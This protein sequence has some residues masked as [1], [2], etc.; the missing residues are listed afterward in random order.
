MWNQLIDPGAL[1]AYFQF[2][3]AQGGWI[4]TRN[5]ARA[6]QMK[7]KS[8]LASTLNSWNWYA[9]CC[10]R[11]PPFV[12]KMCDDTRLIING[13]TNPQ[14][15][16]G[17]SQIN[18]MRAFSVNV[19]QFTYST[20]AA[21]ALY[22]AGQTTSTAISDMI[23]IF[24]LRSLSSPQMMPSDSQVHFFFQAAFNLVLLP[25]ELHHETIVQ[26]VGYCLFLSFMIPGAIGVGP[27]TIDDAITQLRAL[28]QRGNP[29]ATSAAWT[30]LFP[31]RGPNAQL[32]A[33]IV[34]DI[35]SPNRMER[36]IQN[37]Y[38][39]FNIGGFNGSPF[40]YYTID[41]NHSRGAAFGYV[42]P[43][44]VARM[45][46]EII[47][48]RSSG[49]AGQAGS[50]I[51]NAESNISYVNSFLHNTAWH[52]V[53]TDE[54]V[55]VDSRERYVYPL[56]TVMSFISSSVPPS[57]S[58]SESFKTYTSKLDNT[59]SFSNFVGNMHFQFTLLSECYQFY[60]I[61]PNNSYGRAVRSNGQGELRKKAC[62]IL[63]IDP[64]N[65]SEGDL[66]SLFRVFAGF[67][68]FQHPFVLTT[69]PIFINL[70]PHTW[71]FRQAAPVVIQNNFG[72][73]FRFAMADQ[74]PALC[75]PVSY[76]TF[77]LGE[78]FNANP[79]Y[80][81]YYDLRIKPVNL[82]QTP[83]LDMTL[84]ETGDAVNVKAEL[85]VITDLTVRDTFF[86]QY[87]GFGI[88]RANGALLSSCWLQSDLV[89][90]G[91]ARVEFVHQ[92]VIVGNA[93]HKL[94]TVRLQS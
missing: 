69:V 72:T 6:D 8:V 82:I 38:P 47:D 94:F 24:M 73:D 86:A 52:A 84:S 67:P 45:L 59:L 78:A 81:P 23:K 61:A 37:A 87:S 62:G 83:G 39:A 77:A 25:F 4:L 56:N 32:T 63:G 75:V 54:I 85:Q 74:V 22:E 14:T 57:E 42:E 93:Y 80:F 58:P 7:V 65:T 51:S 5:N 13:L 90:A 89:V 30:L 60:A 44:S 31:A 43:R 53:S 46:R 71:V 50:F 1:E 33:N 70:L 10:N 3:A 20:I 49:M 35:C 12:L 2:F 9:T 76:A 26:H 34:N 29:A 41:F 19:N 16:G 48:M 79:V 27:L 21:N 92:D 40:H 15:D 66:K 28:I 88:A 11:L 64:T 36:F 68:A 18:S 17:I 55:P 91:V